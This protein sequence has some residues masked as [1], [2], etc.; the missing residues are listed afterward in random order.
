LLSQNGRGLIQ[1]VYMQMNSGSAFEASPL[2]H[3]V[4]AIASGKIRFEIISISSESKYCSV[5]V[6][7]F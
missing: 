4:E 7:A 6:D 5:F 2:F 3:S 1:N